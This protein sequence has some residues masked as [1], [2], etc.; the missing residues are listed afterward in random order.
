MPPERAAYLAGLIDGEGHIGI[1]RA[2]SNKA[3]AGLNGPCSY[4]LNVCVS[5]TDFDP[6]NVLAEWTGVGVVSR[7]RT[8]ANGTRAVRRW[9][10]WSNQAAC[11]LLTIQPFVLAKK[12]Q[13]DLALEFQRLMRL[14]GRE[15]LTEQEWSERERL[16]AAIAS[17]NHTRANHQRKTA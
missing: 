16:A 14:P 17:H 7:K 5:M 8:P 13:V 12:P 6:L 3:A 2:F 4:R 15:G 11:V 10:A 1:S 9:A